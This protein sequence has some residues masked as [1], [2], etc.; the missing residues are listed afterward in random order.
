MTKKTYRPILFLSIFIPMMVVLIGVGLY[1]FY[2]NSFYPDDDLYLWQIVFFAIV[3]LFGTLIL[4]YELIQTV[5]RQRI[6][7]TDNEIFVPQNTF[8]KRQ[9]YQFE[10]HIPYVEIRDISCEFSTTTS[11]KTP[12][13]NRHKLPRSWAVITL[14]DEKR[15]RISLCYYTSKQSALIL[16]DIISRCAEV[17]NVLN[18]LCGKDIVANCLKVKNNNKSSE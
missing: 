16:D 10:V 14:K 7:L 6:E 13:P 5:V 3:F 11:K 1:C 4:T 9:A 17:G 18:V 12:D 2:K 15:R 8:I